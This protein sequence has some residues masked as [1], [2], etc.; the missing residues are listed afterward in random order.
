MSA[1]VIFPLHKRIANFT[2]PLFF[3][4]IY[5]GFIS[6][7]NVC[8]ACSNFLSQTKASLGSG[9]TGSDFPNCP[10]SLSVVRSVCRPTQSPRF[11]LTWWSWRENVYAPKGGGSLFLF[12]SLFL[13]TTCF[14]LSLFL[15]P[16]RTFIHVYLFIHFS[17][18]I[19]IYTNIFHKWW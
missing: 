5:I 19:Y 7:E 10:K 4:P 12:L 8:C 17:I 1:D 6:F 3:I 11:S 15:S 9:E 16:T 13:L 2:T 14:F 18:H